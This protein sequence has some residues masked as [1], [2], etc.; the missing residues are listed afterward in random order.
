A[1]VERNMPHISHDLS[2]LRLETI[3]LALRSAGDP[4]E[5]AQGGFDVF[6]EAR[7]DVTLYDEV[8]NALTRLSARMPLLALTNGN[9][10]VH[11]VGVGHF[12]QGSIGARE[13]GFAKPDP[14][15]FHAA[16]DVLQCAPHQVLHVGDDPH[17]DVLGALDA[18]MQVAWVNRVGATWQHPQTPHLHVQDLAHLC[19]QLGI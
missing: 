12:F 6:F 9:A 13:A 5:L 10:D 11:R 2:A 18:G 8:V 1:Q 14:R 16:A 17:M 15:I 19:A 7:M 3:R 4:E